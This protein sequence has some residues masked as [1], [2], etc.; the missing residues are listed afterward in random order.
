MYLPKIE[1]K[2]MNMDVS[3][4]I[5]FRHDVLSLLLRQN[6]LYDKVCGSQYSL[7]FAEDLTYTV[8]LSKE[9][10][11]RC[12]RYFPKVLPYLSFCDISGEIDELVT[13]VTLIILRFRVY[14]TLV[15]I[16]NY[17]SLNPASDEEVNNME[18]LHERTER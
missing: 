10:V 12:A 11:K 5:L 8:A 18:V 16:A 3:V 4:E 1:E 9:T 13:L 7:I 14:H 17:S 6:A 2:K 15:K